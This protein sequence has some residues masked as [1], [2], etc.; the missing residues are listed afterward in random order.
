MSKLRNY[1]VPDH[2]GL[3]FCRTG[4]YEWFN[5]IA[6]V[7]GQ[8]PFLKFTLHDSSNL[9]LMQGMTFSDIKGWGPEI[10]LNVLVAHADGNLTW[11]EGR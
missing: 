5:A 2:A 10:N 1:P 4:N 11:A 6:A 7:N 3:Y 8:A 9:S